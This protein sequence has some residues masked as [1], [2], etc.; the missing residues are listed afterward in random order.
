M[1]KTG[2]KGDGDS[3]G[4]ASCMV[5]QVAGRRCGIA[6]KT[7]ITAF[8]SRLFSGTES[9]EA[10]IDSL[11]KTYDETKT[12]KAKYGVHQAVVFIS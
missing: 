4:H 11:G 12:K 9:I 2:M 3:A 7:K 10:Y 8:K 6:K 1:P 5:A